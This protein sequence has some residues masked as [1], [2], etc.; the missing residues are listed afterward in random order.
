MMEGN[1][2]RRLMNAVADATWGDNRE[3]DWRAQAA[4]MFSE[5]TTEYSDEIRERVDRIRR[6][7]PR[8][9]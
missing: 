9:G 2:V 8:P 7:S 5:L 6:P 1:W 3:S 4:L